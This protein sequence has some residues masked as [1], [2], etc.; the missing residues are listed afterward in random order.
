VEG[1]E[2][3]VVAREQRENA[4]LAR[5]DRDGEVD[6]VECDVLF[7]QA[8]RTDDARV[9]AAVSDVERDAGDAARRSGRETRLLGRMGRDV[10]DDAKR[11][12]QVEN[13]A[14]DG[15]SEVEHDPR[16]AV[17]LRGFLVRHLPDLLDD[18]AHRDF[19]MAQKL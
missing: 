19:A 14:V 9:A 5:E 7:T 6:D 16:R 3:V 11:L 1:Y 2:P 13:A 8:A 15:R 10:D 12:E 18:T 17:A 4:E